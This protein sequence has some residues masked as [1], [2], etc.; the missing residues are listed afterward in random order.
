MFVLFG[1]DKHLSLN[2]ASKSKIFTRELRPI[3]IN[4]SS[5]ASAVYL[6]NTKAKTH[7]LTYASFFRAT[8]FMSRN[9]KAWSVLLQKK[10][11]VKRHVSLGSFN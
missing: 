5:S 9:A 8:I 4:A 1:R 7:I 10:D 6:A 2:F 3:G 11:I